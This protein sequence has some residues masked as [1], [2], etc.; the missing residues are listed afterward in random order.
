M[1]AKV[2]EIPDPKN[3]KLDRITRAA[4]QCGD[5]QLGRKTILVAGTNAKGSLVR[6][7]SGLFEASGKTVGSYYSPHVIAREERIQIN[8]QWISESDWSRLEQEHPQA[9]AGLSYFENAT[10]VAWLYFRE[11][12]V[13]LQVLEV[14]MGGRLDATNISDPDLSLVGPI[15]W[16]HQEVLG[17]SLDK[18]AREKAGVMRSL[19]PVWIYGDQPAEAYEALIHSADSLGAELYVSVEA[20]TEDERELIAILGRA[21][22]PA[23]QVKNALMAY[24]SYREMCERWSWQALSVEASANKI[25]DSRLPA[26]TQ[27][28]S[29]SPLWI[30]DG[31]HNLDS[32]SALI[33]NI[34]AQFPS[35]KFQ[36][37]FALMRDKPL[38]EILNQLKSKALGF[39]LFSFY[40]EREWPIEQLKSA[41]ETELA[42]PVSVYRSVHEA[43]E[44]LKARQETVLICGSFYL[45]GEILKN[46]KRPS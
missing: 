42:K 22:L 7:L 20:D 10:L 1:R 29:E 19:R 38:L 21:C 4:R 33:K 37:I 16:D 24:Q 44:Y 32:V 25:L 6:Y 9:V 2:L 12:Q 14:G 18:I 43:I 8:A 13:D 40:P 34:D 15:G 39:H 23:H 26:R 45:A 31:A 27:I 5:P 11:R 30:L 41:V 46:W 35:Q 28:L 17:N 3:Y 36:V